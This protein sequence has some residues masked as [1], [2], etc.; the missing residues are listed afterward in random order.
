M[1][2]VQLLAHGFRGEAITLRASALT[3]ITLF[4]LVPL[5]A[6]VYSA[7]DALTGEEHL[8]L[9]MQAWVNE[10]LGI[11][12]GAAV[13]DRLDAL[14]TKASLQALGVI[15]FAA[16]LVSAVS[17]LWNIES[18]FNHIYAVKRP[19]RPLQRLLTYWM[20]LTLG[21]FLIAG[22]TWASWRIS[23]M[24]AGHAH[25]ALHQH[26]ELMH[27][28][29]AVS[30]VAITYATLAFLYKVLPNAR[31]RLRAALVASFAAGTAWELAKFGFAWASSRLVQV[32]RIYGS[33][34]VLPIVLTWIYISWIIALIG[35]RLCYA[36][37]ASRKPQ[38]HPALFGVLARETF[39]ARAMIALAQLHRA[40]GRPIRPRRLAAELFG[41]MRMVRESLKALRDAGL[42]VESKAG[43][44]LPAR[45]LSQI[46]FAQVRAAA[47][48][49]VRFP[50]R[51]G[52]DLDGALLG[53][54]DSADGAAEGALG[55][56]LAAFLARVPAGAVA[57]PAQ[58]AP[59]PVEPALQ[60]PRGSRAS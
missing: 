6:V 25:R 50:Q 7:I 8:R 9:S 51:E 60:L 40:R 15:G 30:S 26:S 4:S 5:L 59:E 3:Y 47:R 45:D 53:L 48:A 29:T 10:Q 22:S 34:A 12:A 58:A 2:A 33:L 49:S 17:L 36:L 13:A 44:F 19:R 57:T 55:E 16:L 31:V 38:P 43:S 42:V 56:T 41:S 21:P 46:T 18:A 37:D 14:T 32:H 23:Q 11:G 1:R 28:V 20:S 35:C 54:W 27:A 52:D 24:Q 39:V